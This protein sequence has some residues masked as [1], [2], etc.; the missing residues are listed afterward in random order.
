MIPDCNIFLESR[1]EARM[2]D[3]TTRV[4]EVEEADQQYHAATKYLMDEF[5]ELRSLV[6]RQG[7][8]IL[9]MWRDLAEARER[10][11]ELD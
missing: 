3:L 5:K 8:T 10:V 4:D 11:N 2:V 1:I 7:D 6:R 9:S